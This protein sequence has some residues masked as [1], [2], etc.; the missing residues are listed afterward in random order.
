MEEM[1]GQEMSN[2]ICYEGDEF[3]EITQAGT[4][5]SQFSWRSR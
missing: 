1:I 4:W 2:H 3:N 5:N